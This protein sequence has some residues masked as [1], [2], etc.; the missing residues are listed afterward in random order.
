M[1]RWQLRQPR[2]EP[3]LPHESCTINGA[4][5]T[6]AADRSSLIQAPLLVHSSSACNALSQPWYQVCTGFRSLPAKYLELEVCWA[7]CI[8][9]D[10][11][12]SSLMA[13]II[14][15][16]ALIFS[17]FCCSAILQRT[18]PTARAEATARP[19]IAIFM[20]TTATVPLPCYHFFYC[21]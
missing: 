21:Y 11:T 7:E 19:I 4:L 18:I 12:G 16:L 8:I 5:P 1:L 9:S 15:C 6:P 3:I 17:C 13:A 20:A 2:H 14:I 10:I